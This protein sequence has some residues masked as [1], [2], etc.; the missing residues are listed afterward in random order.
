MEN[1]ICKAEIKRERK[2]AMKIIL[3]CWYIIAL[4]VVIIGSIPSVYN[5]ESKND[6]YK[7]HSVLYRLL[8]FEPF[9][10]SKY[11]AA[12]DGYFL[13]YGNHKIRGFSAEW[14]DNKYTDADKI[15]ITSEYL[16]AGN[17]SIDLT[18]KI[19]AKRRDFTKYSEGDLISEIH[20]L[21]ISELII[22]LGIILVIILLPVIIN[23]VL[24]HI[25]KQCELL[26]TDSGIKGI[27]KKCFSARNIQLPV[28]KIDSIMHLTTF[29][30]KLSGGNTV[31][32]RSASALIKFPWVQNADEFTNAAL[33]K[34]DEYK[35]QTKAD[36][37]ILINAVA[38]K[39][40]VETESSSAAKLKELKELLDS[41]VISQEDFEK[42]KNDLL[43]KM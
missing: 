5:Y 20:S 39:T 22:P 42:K 17:R 15:F 41:G 24:T 33:A 8:F 13:V 1:V 34:I 25:S 26:L 37:R 10:C 36:N 11:T 14:F 3:A 38:K 2:K 6:N 21:K 7:E 40:A 43:L 9:R 32:I 29:F 18:K 4:T 31:A 12:E 27:R 16:G 19:Y 28:E 30:N 35:E 23:I